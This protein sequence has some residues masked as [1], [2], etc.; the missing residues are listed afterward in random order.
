[1]TTT[2]RKKPKPSL[3]ERIVRDL[4]KAILSG[5]YAAGSQLPTENE[6]TFR[7]A[8]SRPIVREAVRELKA[9]GL[10]VSRRGSGCF[11][12]EN[13][14]EDPLRMS[15]ERYGTL[16]G[17]ARAYDELL[18][19]RLVVEAWCVRTLTKPEAEKGR[20]RLAARMRKM[21]EVRRDLRAFGSADLAFHFE[22][23][24][25]SGNELFTTIYQGLIPGLGER[26]ARSTYIDLELIDHTLRDHA[27]INEAVQKLDQDEA[28]RRLTEHINWSRAHMHEVLEIGALSAL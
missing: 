12:L 19:L 26:F 25:G 16:R 17:E 28:V 9:R 21:I 27:A 11:V 18:D 10:A 5:E 24:Q 4:E 22:I 2:H 7:Y 13:A 14:W 8:T 23:V 20:L 3:S 1:M 15:L 6:L